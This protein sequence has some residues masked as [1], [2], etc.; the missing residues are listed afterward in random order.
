MLHGAGT[1]AGISVDM[2]KLIEDVC[3]WIVFLYNE[4]DHSMLSKCYI[5]YSHF[6]AVD[7]G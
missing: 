6:V 5:I 3:S 7:Y 1:H 2:K 4:F